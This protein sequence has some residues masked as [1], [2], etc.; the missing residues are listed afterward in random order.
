M[1]LLLPLKTATLAS[2]TDRSTG[3]SA[4]P[5]CCNARS[6]AALPPG[7][8]PLPPHNVASPIAVKG[9]A[10][11]RW[12]ASSIRGNFGLLGRIRKDHNCR[13]ASGRKPAERLSA[14]ARTNRSS[15]AAKPIGHAGRQ[16]H[17]RV[18]RHHLENLQ[19]LLD[20][21]SVQAPAKCGFDI[22]GVRHEALGASTPSVVRSWLKSLT[23]DAQVVLGV[24]MRGPVTLP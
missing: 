21:P 7:I 10:G 20:R 14:I 6:D 4:S 8:S 24:G 23:Q 17:R 9:S 19:R 13:R 22:R 1:G 2:N 3:S 15:D 18:G 5:N 11:T 12:L 16:S